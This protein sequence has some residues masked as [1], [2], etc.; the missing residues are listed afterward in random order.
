MKIDREKARS[1]F[2]EY[3][4][5]YNARDEKVRLKIEHTYRVADLCEVIALS[6][7]LPEEEVDLAW[8]IG[9]LH[10]VG[11]FEQLRQYG[12]FNDAK[13]VDHAKCGAEI[14]FTQGKIR[15]YLE[16]TE[17]DELIRTAV[18]YHNEYRIPENLE[19]RTERFCHIIRDADKI[20]ILKVN[21]EF[22]LEEIYNVSSRELRGGQVS[23]EVLKSFEEE[24]AVLRALKKTA[25]DNVV[26]HI[27]L[28]YE[29]VYPVSIRLVREQGYLDQL[30]N[31]ESENPVT[32]RQFIRIREK[33]TEYLERKKAGK[34]KAPYTGG[35]NVGWHS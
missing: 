16:K 21:V 24:H 25:V 32:Q 23:E 27:S 33:M 19:E 17:E 9:L 26:G 4:E 8:L 18:A 35:S 13:S 30:M 22:P 31:F 12:T 6:L 34:S 29:L 14:L 11:R 3:V 2:A 15:D 20:D 28:V 1:A 10:D 7:G 5:H